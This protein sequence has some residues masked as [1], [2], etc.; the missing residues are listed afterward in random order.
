MVDANGNAVV[1]EI[2]AHPNTDLEIVKEDKEPDRI[3]LIKG[4]REL[5]MDLTEHM[6]RV[7]GMMADAPI[8]KVKYGAVVDGKLPG[9]NWKKPGE[10]CDAGSGSRCLTPIEYEDLIYAEFEDVNKGTLERNFPSCAQKHLAPMLMDDLPRTRLLLE[11]WSGPGGDCGLFNPDMTFKKHT[12]PY[13]APRIQKSF[14]R[15]EL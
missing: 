4:D 6:T 12:P 15:D 5:K 14:A 11:Y 3:N 2:N 9:L 10:A 7:I 8:D 1:C 13:I